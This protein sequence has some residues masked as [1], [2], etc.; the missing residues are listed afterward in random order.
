MPN[1]IINLARK[2]L[3]L[4]SPTW[5]FKIYNALLGIPFLKY[6]MSLTILW[7]TPDYVDI[8]EGK[9][10]FDKDDPVMAGAISVGKFEP[11]TIAIFRS[12]LKEGM[13][14]I[15]IGANLGYF[16]VIAASRVGSS[17]KVFSYE[18]NP[19]NFGLLERNIAANRFRNVTA[20]PIALSN[21]T[22]TRELFF[23]DNQT[24]HSFSDKRGTGRSES[25]VTD[26][27]DNSLK[28]FGYSRIDI[29]KMDIEGAEPLALEGMG[30]TI[31]RNPALII[32]FEFHPNA[33][34]RLGYS[35][36]KFLETFE[37]LGFSMSVIDE[38]CGSCVPI[39][40]LE[41]F[42]ESFLGKEASKNLIANSTSHTTSPPQF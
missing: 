18:P 15:D 29:I 31:A 35:P 39:N 26:T 14:V 7:L 37:R 28:A 30:E 41:A 22:G 12:C 6:F 42:T 38:D 8:A 25:V 17:G 13:T 9:I 1:P 19:H 36:L 23:G 34:K 20:I 33:I 24:T 21:C 2:V 32:I 40:D 5:P 27:L 3:S 10:I 11:E 4:F 16:T